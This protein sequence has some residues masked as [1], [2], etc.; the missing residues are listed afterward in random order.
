MVDA[1][2][3]VITDDQTALV[4][5]RTWQNHFVWQ[6]LLNFETLRRVTDVGSSVLHS[7]LTINMEVHVPVP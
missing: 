6:I 2:Q 3:I 4:S 5:N 7:G 1:F